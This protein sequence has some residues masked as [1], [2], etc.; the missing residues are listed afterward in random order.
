MNAEIVAIGSEMLTPYRQDTNSLFLT[1]RLNELGVEVI[2]KTIVGDRPEHLLQASRTRSPAPRSSIF[3][4][5]LGPT[6][7]DL[8]RECVAEAL[9]LELRRDHEM[10]TALYTRA[11]ALRMRMSENNVKQ[12]D[13]IVGA[14]PS[15]ERARQRSRAVAGDHL[16]RPAAV[17]DSAARPS[18]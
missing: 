9:G 17:G 10:V 8:T 6:E 3:S 1:R 14:E 2:F 13:Y 18:L 4:G 15:E 11:A 12:A 7:D 5:G 16:R